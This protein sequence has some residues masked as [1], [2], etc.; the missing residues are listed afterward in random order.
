MVS[1]QNKSINFVLKEAPWILK[2]LNLYFSIYRPY[3][4]YPFETRLS[5]NLFHV[6]DDNIW[7]D[8]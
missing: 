4:A 3:W 7:I 2:N 1:I 6:A 5:L 8:L